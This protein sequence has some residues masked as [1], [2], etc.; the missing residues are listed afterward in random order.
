MFVVAIDGDDRVVL[1]RLY[2][3]TSGTWSLEV[4]A[5]R[6]D[7][8]DPLVAA[9]RELAEEAGLAAST[10]RHLG[11]LHPANGLLAEDNHVFLATGLSDVGLDRAEMAAEGIDQVRRVPRAEAWSL[12]VDATITDTQTV[13]ALALADQALDRR[14]QR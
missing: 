2:R 3:Y 9:R 5:G 6:T 1:V 10:W 4:P 13:A 7:G 12:V 11:V 14:R 8:E